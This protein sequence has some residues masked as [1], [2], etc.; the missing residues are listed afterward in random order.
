MN[1]KEL[2]DRISIRELIDQ[3]SILGDQRNVHQQVQLFSEDAISE[4]YSEDTILLK[5]KGRKEME[6]AFTGFL[7][8]FETVYHLNGQQII[9]TNRQRE[10]KKNKNHYWG[11]LP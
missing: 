2:E 9:A 10:Q 1:I 3:I 5:L 8:N 11:N 4:T 6:V 7:E